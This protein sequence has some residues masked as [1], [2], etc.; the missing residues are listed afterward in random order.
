[1]NLSRL[2]LP[3]SVT[4]C[5]D[6]DAIVDRIPAF[7]YRVGQVICTLVMLGLFICYPGKTLALIILSCMHL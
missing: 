6:S 7:L 3:D 2:Q 4:D 1:M 5:F